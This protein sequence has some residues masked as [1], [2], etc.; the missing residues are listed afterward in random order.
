[1]TTSSHNSKHDYMGSPHAT[2]S[3]TK[4]MFA[5]QIDSR[6]K[7]AEVTKFGTSERFLPGFANNVPGKELYLSKKGIAINTCKFSPGPKYGPVSSLGN[8]ISSRK[9]TA[10]TYGF[11]TSGRFAKSQPDVMAPD[12]CAPGPGQYNY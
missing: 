12:S 8:Q 5:E 9:T 4:S 3:W 2:K 11:G 1:M 6:K 10:S 7:T